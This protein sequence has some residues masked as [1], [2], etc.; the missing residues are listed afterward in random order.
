[1]IHQL[2][3]MNQETALLAEQLQTAYTGQPWFG[4]SVREILLEVDETIV[5][6]KING[7]HS[8][9]ELVWHMI[10]WKEFTISRLQ[11]GDTTPAS[12]FDDL[13][14]RPLDHA[15]KSLWK[16]GLQ[17]LQT[18]QAELIDLMIQ[19]DDAILSQTVPDRN[20]DFRTLL[21]G[22]TEHDIYHLGQ[23]AYINKMLTGTL[24]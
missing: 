7:Q 24:K 1:M 23:I 19:Q 22:I 5:F 8:I 13:D 10:T 16:S 20:Y 21:T 14:W 9:L 17:R 6:E 11:K 15:D 4:K 2:K 12:Y 18:L 3:L